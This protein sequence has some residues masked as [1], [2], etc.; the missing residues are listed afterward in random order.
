VTRRG[1]RYAGFPPGRWVAYAGI[2]LLFGPLATGEAG[3]YRWVDESG[4]VHY[5]DTI[6]PDH[7]ERARTEFSQKGLP[8]AEVPRAMT[9]EEIRRERELARLRAQQQRLIERLEAADRVLLRSFRT[10]NDLIVA[11]DG[12]TAAIDAMVRVTRNNILRQEQWLAGLR[13][14]AANLERSGRP[15]PER[16]KDGIRNAES[17]IREANDAIKARQEQKA[18]IHADFDE[19]LRRFRELSDRGTGANLSISRI[20]EPSFHEILTCED[21]AHCDALWKR[22]A[23]YLGAQESFSIRGGSKEGIL[24]ATLPSHDDDLRLA[25]ARIADPEGPG[26]SIFLE[27]Q[28]ATTSARNLCRRADILRIAE[29]FREAVA[30]ASGAGLAAPD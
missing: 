10:E 23:R 12:K 18:R 27:L 9:L 7:V 15:V 3:L 6:P 17:A 1:T 14:E 24:V 28:C 22:A 16:L 30:P 2:A 26:A 21:D 11:R 4:N 5:T 8:G 20:H 19:D 13:A 25:L 29:G